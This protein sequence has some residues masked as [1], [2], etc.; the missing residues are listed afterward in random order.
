M[1]SSTLHGHWQ[2]LH[3]RK[4]NYMLETMDT[5]TLKSVFERHSL[6][7]CKNSGLCGSDAEVEEAVGKC[8][9]VKE[10]V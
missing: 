2:S 6:Q 8:G 10:V 9:C 5:A 7:S 4:V 3:S 1:I